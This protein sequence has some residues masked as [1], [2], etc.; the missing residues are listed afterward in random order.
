LAARKQI[1]I[2]MEIIHPNQNLPRWVA[3]L[4]IKLASGGI[5]IT[6]TVTPVQ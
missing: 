6:Q 4:E 2:Q 3:Q 5:T 1:V